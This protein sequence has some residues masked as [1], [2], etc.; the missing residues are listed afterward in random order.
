MLATARGSDASGTDRTAALVRA[1]SRQGLATSDVAWI[2]A[3][4]E[5][6]FGAIS[7]TYRALVRASSRGEPNDLYLVHTRLSPGGA[8]VDVSGVSNMTHTPSADESAP[9]VDGQLAVYTASIEGVTTSVYA[10]DLSRERGGGEDLSRT[11]RAQISITNWQETGQL[12][13]ITRRGWTFDPSPTSLTVALRSDRDIDIT[14][15]G[16]P[17]LLPREGQEA[18]VGAE[19]IRPHR[20]ARSRPGNLVT[21]AVDRVRNLSWFGDNRMQELKAAVFT[22]I[23]AVSRVERLFLADTSEKDIATDLGTIANVKPVA[24][25]DPETGWP[26]A[27]MKPYITPALP[28][29]GQWVPLDSDPFLLTN[30]GAPP[31]FLT[32]FIRTDRERQYTRIYVTLWDPRQVEMH[33]MAGTVEPIGASGEAGPGLVPRTPE[34]IGRFVAGMNGGFQALHGEFGMMGDGIVYLPPKPYA[35]T[36]AALRDGS[37]GFGSWPADEGVPETIL[38]FRQNLTVL[39]KDEKFNPFGRTW[40]GGTPPGQADKVHSVRTGICLTVDDFIAYFYGADIAAEVLAQGMIR[41]RCKFGIHLDMNVGHTGLEFYHVAPA[42]E[43]PPIGR[44]LQGDWEAEG[45]VPGLEGWNFRGRRMIRGMPLMNFPRYIHREAR[46]FFY[47]TLRHMLPGA[48][49]P[50]AAGGAHWRTHGLPQH[51][52]PFA[53]ATTQVTPDAN[54]PEFHVDLLKIDPRTVAAQGSGDAD[55]AAPTVVEFSGITRAKADHPALWLTRGAF[56]IG[57][58]APEGATHLLSGL[59]ETESKAA[60]TATAAVGVTDEDGM[61]VYAEST[62]DADSAS[63]LDRLLAG[64]GCGTRM[65]LAHPLTPLLGGTTSLAGTPVQPADVGTVR[66]LRRQGSGARS[67]FQDTPITSP[68]IWQPL[69]MRRVRY[70]KKPTPAASVTSATSPEDPPPTK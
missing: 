8:L 60:P 18:L 12:A 32:S 14:A 40:W 13:G 2:D 16:H 34:V 50:S 58:E 46:D 7:R 52:F 11:A 70:F 10:V 45:A 56:S 5:S 48:D 25:T 59:S 68:E 43:L 36:V 6:I 15:D 47:L 30:P 38:S 41:A 3:P 21:W 62:A 44:P 23:D 19:L 49:V 39:V 66:L 64:L 28:G 53:L 31:A 33:M 55:T 51:G 17:I 63:E 4:P 54:R 22:V 24:F 20:T 42:S 69:Q 65:L 57:V 61:L 9:I 37:T 27:P 67:I 35:A 1:L 29:E 26:P